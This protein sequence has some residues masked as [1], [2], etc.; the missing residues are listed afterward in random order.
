[1]TEFNKQLL[2]CQYE[3]VEDLRTELET[4][5]GIFM[6]LTEEKIVLRRGK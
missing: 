2:R 4:E 6:A 1:M 5:T 3:D